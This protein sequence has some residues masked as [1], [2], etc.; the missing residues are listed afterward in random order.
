MLELAH[1]PN[2]VAPR[3]AEEM[4]IPKIIGE[5]PI[6]EDSATGLPRPGARP[7]RPGVENVVPEILAKVLKKDDPKGESGRRKPKR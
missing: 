3:E 6:V 5:Q 2:L 7:G 1:H 4:K